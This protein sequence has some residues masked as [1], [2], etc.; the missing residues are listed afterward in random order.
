M[1]EVVLAAEAVGCRGCCSVC[2]S[3]AGAAAQ[4]G[5]APEDRVAGAVVALAAEAVAE[6]SAGAAIL[7]AA[8][9]VEVGRVSFSQD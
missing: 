5:E 1:D 4:V 8:A 3:I 2:F 7:V 9:P 6:A